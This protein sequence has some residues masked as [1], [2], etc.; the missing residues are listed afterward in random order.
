MQ[1]GW[2][3]GPATTADAPIA[4]W[5][6]RP[7]YTMADFVTLLWGER[8]LML[9]VFALIFGAGLAVAFTLPTTY[10]ANSSLLVRLGQEYVYQPRAGDAGRGAALENDQVIQAEI[11][12]LSSAQLKQQVVKSIGLKRLFPDLAEAYAAAPVAERPKIEG[13]AVRAIAEEM[14]IGTAPE[15]PVIRLQYAHEDPIMAAEVLNRLTDA[16]LVYRK[17][18]LLDV[19]PPLLA[20]Q[21]R[22]FQTRLGAADQAYEAFLQ[23]H[24]IGDF[25]AE[26]Q[27]LNA[28]HSAL[29]DEA[30]RVDA[31]LQEVQ[32]RL[33]AISAEFAQA[34]AEIGLQRDVN[35]T[36]ADKLLE[37]RIE[38]EELLGRYTADARPVKEL[39]ARIAQLE[40]LI[41]A[42]GGNGEQARRFG[43]NPVYQ[44]LQTEKIQLQA[45]AASLR[46]RRQALTA[47]I[48][49]VGDRRMD[50]TGLEPEFLELS[51]EKDA[52]EGNLRSFVQ[53]EQESQAAQ[54]IADKVNDNI[55]VLARAVVPTQGSSLKRPVA[56][57]AFLFAGFTALSL[58]L[59]RIFLR[60]GF[61][62]PT[63][64]ARTL[65]LPVL[66]T[67]PI[68]AA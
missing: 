46:E 51:R 55:R 53:R 32:G 30:Y 58:G 17:Q 68:K 56:A 44:T 15:T 19:L 48:R 45:E 16:Y 54:S 1:G 60:R 18:V 13:A 42:G 20:E 5:G 61:A 27:A 67:A 37:L 38:R 6:A 41:A 43:V 28:L 34:P 62:T 10:A 11:E 23:A 65:D 52:L 9:A 36:S 25:Q 14:S 12:I 49:E 8:F 57:L 33:A 22:A 39:D 63:S 24:R 4:D 35:T 31:R 2:A 26:K 3:R 59:A 29:T 66:A 47:Q 21:R 7:R 50:M 40:A 64:A